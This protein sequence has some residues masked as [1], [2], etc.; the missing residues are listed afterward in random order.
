MTPW[1]SNS[2]CSD[3]KSPETKHETRVGRAFL[4]NGLPC[5]DARIAESQLQRFEN[6]TNF[7]LIFLS[8]LFWRK[9]GKPPKKARIFSLCRTPEIP[10][11]EGKNAQKSKEIPCNERSKEIQKSKER[12]IRVWEPKNTQK[13][14]HTVEFEIIT[15]L[16]R[17]GPCPVIFYGK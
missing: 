4:E 5:L 9:Q 15:E 12:K 16:F 14:T 8:L 7:V 3:L 2:D 13:K 1:K 10:G 11:K 17:K 6:A